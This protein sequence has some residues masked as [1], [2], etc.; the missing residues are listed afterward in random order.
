[1]KT[2]SW[3]KLELLTPDKVIPWKS[4]AGA[5]VYVGKKRYV[6]TK[7]SLCEVPKVGESVKY[8][9]RFAFSFRSWAIMEVSK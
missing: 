3:G 1:M 7:D 5:F 4:G 6:W 9:T 2:K 8:E